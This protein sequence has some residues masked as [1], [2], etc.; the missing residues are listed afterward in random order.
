VSLRKRTEPD[1]D[2]TASAE[3]EQMPDPSLADMPPPSP[4]SMTKPA[5]NA[6]RR[7]GPPANLS[8]VPRKLAIQLSASRHVP[9]TALDWLDAAA[10]R[11]RAVS[12][13]G[14]MH[15]YL[16]EVRQDSFGIGMPEGYLTLAV[17]D[18]V[19]SSS[20]SHTG[21]AFAA[22]TSVRR[23]DLMQALDQP[24]T[25]A[26]S[27][28]FLTNTMHTLAAE[29]GLQPRQLSTTLVL[30]AIADR[31]PPEGDIEVTLAQVGDSSA[32]RLRDGQWTEL[33]AEAEDAESP[34]ITAVESLPLYPKAR[35]W[36][37]TF[38]PGETLAL[39]SD[40]VG[41]ILPANRGFADALAALWQVDAPA[42]AELL[43]VL[44]ATVK[45]YDDDRTFVGLRFADRPE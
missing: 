4:E 5:S 30:A 37:E 7:F 36:R 22:R 25:A 40:G 6:P 27:L 39:V 29:A 43:S 12:T 41:N 1:H 34:I 26:V 31:Q 16:G 9:D 19:G 13:R 44:D 35:V 24:G 10:G 45:S 32:W 21:S 33:G 11:I 2:L 8:P 17:A 42:P 3:S 15:R 28:D 14:H 38:H 18:G 23:T 20:A